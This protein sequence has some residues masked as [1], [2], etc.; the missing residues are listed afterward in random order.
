MAPFCASGTSKLSTR[1]NKNVKTFEFLFKKLV[2]F[3]L[4]FLWQ[5][6]KIDF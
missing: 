1:T 6:R 3:G 4:D 2:Y 5:K